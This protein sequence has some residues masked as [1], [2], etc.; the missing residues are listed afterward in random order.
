[1]HCLRCIDYAK[2]SK[3]LSLVPQTEAVSLQDIVQQPIKCLQGIQSKIGITL[4]PISRVNICPYI[5]TG[6][7][8]MY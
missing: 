5:V 2:V 4:R 8:D 6:M 1:M 7:Y 3:G